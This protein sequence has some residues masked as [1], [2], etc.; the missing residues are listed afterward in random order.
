LGISVLFRA[1]QKYNTYSSG[2]SDQDM[3]KETV[4]F[5]SLEKTYNSNKF[6]GGK[7]DC[8]FAGIKLDLRSVKLATEG[9]EL[10]V[11]AIFGGGEILVNKN[12]R[13]QASGTGVFGGWNNNFESGITDTNPVLRIKGSAVFGGVEIKN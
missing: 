12:M 10:E 13:V 3:I 6:R 4:A 8:L 9:A 7:V 2:K 5:G 11:N 1:P